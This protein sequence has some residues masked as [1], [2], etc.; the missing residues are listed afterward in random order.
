MGDFLSPIPHTQTISVYSS[1][2]LSLLPPPL[3]HF[4]FQ[5]MFLLGTFALIFA[6]WGGLVELG[7]ARGRGFE[8]QDL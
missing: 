8:L 5:F 6:H 1:L 7:D 2:S 4:I 3:A